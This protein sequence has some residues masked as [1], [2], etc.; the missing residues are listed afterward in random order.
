MHHIYKAKLLPKE[1]GNE[2]EEND[3]EP[4]Q[5]NTRN[6]HKARARDEK[7]DCFML[8]FINAFAESAP[9]L[10]VQLYLYYKYDL[11]LNL[12]RGKS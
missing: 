11:E 3:I 2:T 10:F 7:R 5:G 9:Q 6:W 4:K 8:D 12:L 1:D